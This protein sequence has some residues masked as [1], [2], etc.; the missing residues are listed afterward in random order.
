MQW[1]CRKR[2]YFLEIHISKNVRVNVMPG[3]DLK[4]KEKKI[5]EISVT[6]IFSTWVVGIWWFIVLFLSICFK[7]FHNKK[8]NINNQ[9]KSSTQTNYQTEKCDNK[10]LKK[11][12]QKQIKMP[13]H[14][15]NAWYHQKS[16][17]EKVLT[18]RHNF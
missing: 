5:G 4:H 10:K 16:I 14:E 15:Q 17:N 11:K 6:N 13:P 18:I 2:S 3:C 1:Y 12:K 7:T 9:T 8:V